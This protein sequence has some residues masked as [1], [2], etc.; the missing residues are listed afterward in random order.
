MIININLHTS[1]IQKL[2]QNIN[3]KFELD[4]GELKVFLVI[5]LKVSDDC[6]FISQKAG[7]KKLP[8]KFGM[9]EFNPLK[10]IV[11]RGIQSKIRKLKEIKMCSHLEKYMEISCIS[12]CNQDQVNVIQW[13]KGEG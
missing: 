13:N 10:T 5:K 6:L 4:C 9:S 12:C 11:E 7:M 3:E 2:N 1:T 8:N